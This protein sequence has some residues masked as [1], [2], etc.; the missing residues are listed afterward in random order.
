LFYAGVKALLSKPEENK[1]YFCEAKVYS[2]CRS[3]LP[4]E[5]AKP[6]PGGTTSSAKTLSLCERVFCFGA[7]RKKLAF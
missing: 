2:I 6:N 1:K 4:K 3:G 5:L 7:R